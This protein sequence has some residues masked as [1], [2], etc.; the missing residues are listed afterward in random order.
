MSV[1]L[2]LQRGMTFRDLRD[3]LNRFGESSL[4]LPVYVCTSTDD[5]MPV[6]SLTL[7]D[8]AAPHVP[9]NPLGF[10]LSE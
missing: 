5:N 3:H 9:D 1:N 4:D 8:S 10:N 6:Q 7:F 2:E